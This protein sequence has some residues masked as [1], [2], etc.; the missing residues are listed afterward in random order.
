MN[1]QDDLSCPGF[2]AT[3]YQPFVGGVYRVYEAGMYLMCIT[4]MVRQPTRSGNGDALRCEY[5]IYSDPDMGE[6]HSDWMNLYNNSDQA[7]DIACRQ[8]SAICHA[9]GK[10]RIDDL[11]EIMNLPMWIDLSYEEATIGGVNQATGQE[12]K[13]QP[14]R[15]RILR[16]SPYDANQAA[17]Q[18]LQQVAAPV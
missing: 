4:D 3:L 13:G 2:D 12:V 10:L 16:W 7:R 15:N 6:K 5:T 18:P 9:I 14:A 8:L 17:P 1:P 11:R